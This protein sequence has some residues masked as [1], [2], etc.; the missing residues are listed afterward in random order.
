MQTVLRL[1]VL[2][3]MHENGIDA[4]VNPEN[5]LPPFK[6]GRPREPMVD[7][8]EPTA[9]ARRSRPCWAVRRSRCPRATTRWCTNPR[10]AL[11]ADKTKYEA[12]HR[13]GRIEAAEPDADQPHVLGGAWR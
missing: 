5:T 11:S 3:V 7:N 6:L 10:Y 9:A 12:G 4:F 2:K 8:R 13:N 1:V